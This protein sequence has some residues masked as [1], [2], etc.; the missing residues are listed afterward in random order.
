MYADPRHLH[1]HAI[2]TRFDE[3]TFDLID[4]AAAFAGKQRAALVREIVEE[5]LAERL[6]GEEQNTK[7]T[8]A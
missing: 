5:W 6:A 1:D 4:A 8:A 3:R 2:K 7:S